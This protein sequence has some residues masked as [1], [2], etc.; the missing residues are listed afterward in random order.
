MTH[1]I[2]TSPRTLTITDRPTVEALRTWWDARQADPDCALA[3]ADNAPQNFSELYTR[4][5]T[6]AYIFYLVCVEASEIAG[7]MWLHDVQSDLDGTPCAGWVGAYVLPAHRHTGLAAA[8]WQHIH[9][10]LEARGVRH[11]FAAVHI[12]NVRSQVYAT[13]HMGLH[14]VDRFEKFTRFGGMLTDCLIYTLHPEDA[15]DAWASAQARAQQ[16]RVPAAPSA[17]GVDFVPL[18]P[19]FH[20]AI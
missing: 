16:Q 17:R 5:A 4:I 18:E 3:F 12:A 20:M 19:Y 6:E 13:R 1:T 10:R 9:M 7:A 14:V 11:F 15:A 8:M 2:I